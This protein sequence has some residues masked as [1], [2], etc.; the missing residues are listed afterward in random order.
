MWA[1]VNL[2]VHIETQ[3]LH[4][5]RNK[6][7]RLIG[8]SEKPKTWKEATFFRDAVLVRL[9]GSEIC[10]TGKESTSMLSSEGPSTQLV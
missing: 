6:H 3:A 10:L 7:Y 2:D 5:N 1:C 9:A 4:V 8:F